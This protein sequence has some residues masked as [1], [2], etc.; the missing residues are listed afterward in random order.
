[1][2][3]KG[4]VV[5][6]KN[7]RERVGFRRGTG[8]RFGVEGKKITIQAL[9][10]EDDWLLEFRQLCKECMAASGKEVEDGIKRARAK[11]RAKWLNVP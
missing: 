2:Y 10:D 8:I 3:D 4:I 1:M 6:P 5:I 7:I 11:R 9:G